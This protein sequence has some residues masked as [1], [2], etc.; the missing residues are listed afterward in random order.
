M[1]K[2]VNGLT[3]S[4]LFLPVV[5]VFR[6]TLTTWSCR[7]QANWKR[8]WT[9]WRFVSCPQNVTTKNWRTIR[10]PLWQA[11][12]DTT[13]EPQHEQL[14]DF[15]QTYHSIRKRGKP[16]LHTPA[17][18]LWIHT[19]ATLSAIDLHIVTIGHTYRCSVSCRTHTVIHVYKYSVIC[20]TL[21]HSNYRSYIQMQCDLTYTCTYCHTCIRVQLLTVIHL[22]KLLYIQ[23]QCYQ[24]F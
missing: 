2:N 10:P 16:A 21:A 9:S 13:T 5:S 6:L 15:W 12:R 11:P 24:P 7:A 3:I 4:F 14:A 8:P 19:S 20:H 1:F 18:N 17:V 23:M 22:Y